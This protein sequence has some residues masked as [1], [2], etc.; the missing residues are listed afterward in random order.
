MCVLALFRLARSE[1]E[2]SD[3]PFRPSED[4]TQVQFL[5][6]CPEEPLLLTRD[7]LALASKGPFH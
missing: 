1:M 3:F 5:G 7:L 6:A 4:K 2:N